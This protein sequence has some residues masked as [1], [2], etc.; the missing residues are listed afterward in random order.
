MTHSW[1]IYKRWWLS[2][3]FLTTATI[4]IAQTF[5]ATVLPDSVFARMRGRSYPEGCKVARSDLRY[6]RLSHWTS[7]D[8]EQVGE[9]VCNKAIADDLLDIFR[10][11]HKAHYII[12]SIRLIDDFNADDERSMCANNT[13]CFCYRAVAGSKKLSRHALG[14][15]VDINPLYNPC[16]RQQ[17]SG[18]RTVQPTTASPYVDRQRSFPQKIDKSD[19]CYRL[20]VAHGF[21]WGGAWKRSKDYQHFE[22]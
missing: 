13:S 3:L 21:R 22:K 18:K 20:F 17:K 5:T 19:L 16:V 10:Q 14:M 9:M 2:V 15:A 1:S 7:A 12:E 11:L 8:K 6:L 4:A